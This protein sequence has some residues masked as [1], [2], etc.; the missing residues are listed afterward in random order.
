MTKIPKK[1]QIEKVELNEPSSE[2]KQIEVTI[3]LWLPE[4]KEDFNT[5]MKAQDYY[6]ALWDIYH[7]CR[8]VWKYEEKPSQDRVELAERLGQM[9]ADT[10][11]MD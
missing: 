1:P 7:E 6:S 8:K 3:K 2:D 5:M 11:I 10:G 9:A 4:H